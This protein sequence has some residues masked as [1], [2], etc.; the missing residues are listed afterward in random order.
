VTLGEVQALGRLAA[1]NLGKEI[2]E[3]GPCDG[4][5]LIEEFLDIERGLD[6]VS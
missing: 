3:H 4:H 6:E 5:P 1:R 2:L